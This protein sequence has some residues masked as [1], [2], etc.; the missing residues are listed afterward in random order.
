[1]L[2]WDSLAPRGK[3]PD[4]ERGQEPTIFEARLVVLLMGAADVPSP[5]AVK[6]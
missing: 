5:V 6:L 4:Q 1:M 2:R 3:A